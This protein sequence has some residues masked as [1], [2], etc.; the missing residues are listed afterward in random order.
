MISRFASRATDFTF[1]TTLSLFILYLF[2]GGFGFLN[3]KDHKWISGDNIAAYI[4]QLYYVDDVWRWP[5]AANPNFGLDMSTSLTYTGPALPI[6]FMQKLLGISPELQ[7]FG[8]WLLCMFVLQIQLAQLVGRAVGLSSNQSRVASLLFVSPFLIYRMQFHFWL[9]AHFLLLWSIY[10]AI[11]YF[12]RRKVRIWEIG[13]ISIIGYITVAYLWVMCF[14]IMAF[15][16][17]RELLLK[18]L[19][20]R[21]IR[22]Y[23][24]TALAPVFFL[25][26][27]FDFGAQKASFFEA[28]RMPFTGDYLAYPSNLLALF[29]PAVGYQRDCSQGHCYWGGEIIPSHFIQNFSALSFDLGGVQGNYDAFLYVGLGVI[30]IFLACLLLQAF[31]SKPKNVMRKTG[32]KFT[33]LYLSTLIAFAV[34]YRITVGS[35]ELQFFD[36]KYLRW[37]LSA[38]RASGRFMWIVAYALLV[39]ALYLL[40]LRLKPK[41]VTAVLLC[42]SLIQIIDLMPALETRFSEIRKMT[43]SELAYSNDIAREFTQISTGKTELRVFPTGSNLGWPLISYLSWKN[44]LAS[45]LFSSARFNYGEAKRQDEK[46]SRQICLGKV[47]RKTLIILS[48]DSLAGFSKCKL[49]SVEK[50]NLGEFIFLRS[51]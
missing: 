9:T 26:F 16:I 35:L 10:V 40:V 22:G 46:L 33:L 7:F 32:G 25:Y 29:N 48:K 1:S 36:I 24:L 31:N 11:R 19:S 30:L 39:F 6:A 23:A 41:L 18:N 27:L 51:D 15:P 4:A 28:L 3:P 14:I 44:D 43:T 42:A 34:T 49:D 37:A 47:S 2:W 38:F 8:L 20:L 50:I 13:A 12:K 45:G 5:L 17:L 21:K